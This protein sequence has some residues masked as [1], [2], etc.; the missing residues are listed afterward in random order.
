MKPYGIPRVIGTAGAGYS[1]LV[2]I[3]NFG[4]KSSVSRI[5]SKSGDIKNSFRNPDVKQARRRIYKT[6][7]RQ[8][9]KRD[10][11]NE[12]NSEVYHVDE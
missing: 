5:R 8:E 4:L 12:I 10:I 2:D 7:A 3:E 6:R 11:I 9:A 1:D